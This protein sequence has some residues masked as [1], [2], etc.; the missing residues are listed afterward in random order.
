MVEVEAQYRGSTRMDLRV[1]VKSNFK[2]K[3]IASDIEIYIP[4]PCDTQSPEIEAT[5]GEAGYLPEKDSVIWQIPELPGR[6]EIYL[7]ATFSLPSI[8]SSDR[9]QFTKLPVEV[10]FDIESYTVS[11]LQ[12]R[13]LK[14]DEPS[15]YSGQS[16]VRYVTRNGDYQIRTDLKDLV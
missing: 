12:V 5:H 9:D 4:V 13:Y 6:K 10:I 14:I 11:G 2:S 16:W 3:C 15:G 7:E 8:K 1:K